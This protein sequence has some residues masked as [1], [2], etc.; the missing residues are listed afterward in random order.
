MLEIHLLPHYE[1]LSA[2]NPFGEAVTNPLFLEHQRLT[3]EA[4]PS[5]L[6]TVNTYGA[7][8]GKTLAALLGWLAM[9]PARGSPLP[10]MLFIA[11]TNELIAQHVTTIQ[12]FAARAGLDIHVI[13]V[14]SRTLRAL[15][16]PHAHER[17]GERL[18]RLIENPQDYGYVGRKPIVVVTN[19]D[20]FYYALYF[21][22]YNRID[23]R[24]LFER[25]LLRFDYVVID[26]FHY[27]SPKQLACFLFFFALC[28]EWGYFDDGRRVCLLS[29]TPEQEIRTYLGRLF[30]PNQMAWIAPEDLSPSGNGL[31]RTPALAP[32]TLRIINGTINDFT[33]SKDGQALLRQW[34]NERRDG[35]LISNAL[36]RINAAH[37]ALR[38]A[39]F[40]NSMA[41]LTGA[42]RTDR[43]R[44][45][46][47]SQLLLATPTVDIGYN[48][49]KLGKTRQPLDFIIFDARTRDA[50]L[51]R[52]A[53]AGRVLGRPQTNVPSD[54][55]AL[56][57]EEAYRALMPFD[58]QTLSRMDFVH[59]VQ[60][61]MRPRFDLY[62]YLRSYAV[63]E[64][65]RP[66][67]N[68]ERMTRPDLHEWIGRLFGLVRDI[69]APDTRRNNY[70]SLR[71]W[72]AFHEKLER[73]V[74][75]K[76]GTALP[77]VLDE[78]V[79]WHVGGVG[80]GVSDEHMVDVRRHLASDRQAQQRV[81]EWGEGQYHLTEALYNFREAFQA[82][83][84]CVSDPHHLLS[85]SA[86]T[87][88]DALHVA[89]HF[90]VDWFADRHAFEQAIGK[91]VEEADLY[92]HI[93][94]WRPTQLT[95]SF[96]YREPTLPRERFEP[97]YTRRPVVLKGLRLQGHSPGH[98]GL[99]PLDEAL[100]QAIENQWVPLLIGRPQDE[101][102]LRALLYG[103]DI[104]LRYLDVSFAE[105]TTRYPAIVGTAA[106]IV[107]AE[108]E[109]YLRF[110]AKLEDNAPIFVG[111]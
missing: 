49:E 93:R 45:A 2:K 84:A 97:L 39:G 68:L 5:H 64:A 105:G 99:F 32:L 51:Q 48:F 57:D 78:Y 82:P 80:Q 91:C 43:R 79:R 33:A 8:T 59:A 95:F 72:L 9:G 85:D 102:R 74:V 60:S 86:T 111:R 107:H 14:D 13:H 76:E 11:P 47:F 69:F 23:R 42:E 54:A 58:G 20:I 16:T 36:W 30:E 70:W 12:K 7:G 29:A 4:V 40:R 28:K 26:E 18:N 67:F 25:F 3:A 31:K 50:F 108:L 65:F 89:A 94:G 35:A 56:M 88:Y 75:R 73:L 55:V 62:A 83:T 77:D 53:R 101:G 41:R 66:I 100:R 37:S 90:K 24:N 103:R 44:A 104:I 22:A 34:F 92:C 63:L 109:G 21:S 19:P 98:E 81:R 52:L 110:R 27:Y 96:Y 61:A 15:D 46:P 87:L 6:L 17:V 106:F 10:N 38:D 1:A 71:R